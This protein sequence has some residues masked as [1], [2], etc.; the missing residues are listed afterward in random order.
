MQKLEENQQ[1]IENSRINLQ[2]QSQVNAQDNRSLSSVIKYESMDSI[3]NSQS[4]FKDQ[5]KNSNS[6]FKVIDLI[7]KQDP[8]KINSNIK[9]NIS[10]RSNS[11]PISKRS[12]Y[13]SKPA[14]NSSLVEKLKKEREERSKSQP[15]SKGR[16]L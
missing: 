6:L 9:S 7:D 13:L 12:K 11:T 4:I 16:S 2:D 5:N 3:S 10:K 1:K 8:K 14:S 15:N